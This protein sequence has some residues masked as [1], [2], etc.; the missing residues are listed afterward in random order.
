[1]GGDL[2]PWDC[3]SPG[4]LLCGQ[5]AIGHH[6]EHL[7]QVAI[8]ITPICMRAQE[9]YRMSNATELSRARMPLPS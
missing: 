7:G 2:Q 6:G 3:R 8:P 5:P 4:C 9:A 1:M